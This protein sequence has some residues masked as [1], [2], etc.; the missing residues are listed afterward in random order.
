MS[1]D[2]ISPYYSGHTIAAGST[3][4]TVFEKFSDE[5]SEFNKLVRNGEEKNMK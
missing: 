1:G 5:T 4:N 3:K 2:V